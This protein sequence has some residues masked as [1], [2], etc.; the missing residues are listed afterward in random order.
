MSI[1]QGS[2]CH[3]AYAVP[4]L[5]GASPEGEGCISHTAHKCHAIAHYI[6][7]EWG[8]CTYWLATDD[9]S[10]Q[11]VSQC[12]LATED[13]PVS[14]RPSASQQQTTVLLVC[15]L[16]HL[17]NRRPS[18]KYASQHILA[19]DDTS[20]RYVSWHFLETDKTSC[21]Y[22]V[23]VLALEDNNLYWCIYMSP[24]QYYNENSV[25]P[26]RYCTRSIIF[27]K[28]SNGLIMGYMYYV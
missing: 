14:M 2:Q 20:C 19:T 28:L 9:V 10:C 12:F 4:N 17:S 18:C 11:Y 13:R 25:S 6:S 23:C 1:Q 24:G 7:Q 8:T 27:A 21:Q 26:S 3:M 15:V 22:N 5:R 16:A